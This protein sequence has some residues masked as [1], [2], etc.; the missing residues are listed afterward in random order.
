MKITNYSD[1][2]L[3]VLMYLGVS[4]DS[5]ATIAEIAEKH[6]ISRNHM[7]KIVHHLGQLGYVK[8][9]RGKSGGICL[10]MPA[11]KIVV[12]KVVRQTES[13]LELVECFGAENTCIHSPGCV[14][15]KALKEALQ[16]FLSTLDS[17]TLADLIKPERRIAKQLEL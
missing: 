15:K 16:A 17:Y 3:R 9:V 11:E 10:G 2:S 13:N 4:G 7:V 6:D 12:G 1:Y 5:L 14:L 8:T